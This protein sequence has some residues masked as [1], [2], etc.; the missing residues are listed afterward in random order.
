MLTDTTIS[1]PILDPELI[2][3]PIDPAFSSTRAISLRLARAM[4]QRYNP[5]REPNGQFGSGSGGNAV[6]TDIM[7]PS[8]EPVT[9]S[10][11]NSY[12]GFHNAPTR[13]D[14]APLHDLTGNEIYP[15][16]VYAENNLKH[17]TSGYQEFDA[18]AHQIIK[19]VEGNP[20]AV[21]EIYRAIPKD[22]EGGINAGDWVTP[23]KGYAE[24]HGQSNLNDNF[25]IETLSVKASDLFT[26]GNSL[27]EW[28]Y[29]PAPSTK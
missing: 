2:Q 27:L 18:E 22:V 1:D 5:N 29:D 3:D 19:S 11:S 8:N 23:I 17:Y 20:D 7:N 26:E 15:A 9:P 10:T 4:V 12:E 6:G 28:G 16:N 25:K 21:V 13:E 24:Q 14:G